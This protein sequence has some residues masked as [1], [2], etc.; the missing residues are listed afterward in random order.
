[1]EIYKSC[2][3]FQKN[4]LQRNNKCLMNSVV[5]ICN[6]IK[7]VVAIDSQYIMWMQLRYIIRS[8]YILMKQKFTKIS[9]K[10]TKCDIWCSHTSQLYKFCDVYRP[11]CYIILFP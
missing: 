1:M 10:K 9:A 11:Y 8:V 3:F 5:E 6:E 4:T 2:K 7:K